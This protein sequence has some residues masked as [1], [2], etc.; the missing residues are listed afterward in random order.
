LSEPFEEREELALR[1]R[2][3]DP[4]ATPVPPLRLAAA[5][6]S[7][8]LIS[9]SVTATREAA[10][11]PLRSARPVSVDTPASEENAGWL[12]DPVKSPVPAPANEE[13]AFFMRLAMLAKDPDEESEDCA[14]RITSG[15]KEI[16]PEA[17]SVSV[18]ENR[19]PA[20]PE[21]TPEPTRA[22]PRLMKRSASA[23][24]VD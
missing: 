10:A 8:G 2:E 7:I 22:D 16:V 23:V 1:M 19:Y 17:L 18:M 3:A 20:L 5:R 11:G 4:E 13:S 21:M 9:A 15:T 6:I 24:T 14:G 12:S